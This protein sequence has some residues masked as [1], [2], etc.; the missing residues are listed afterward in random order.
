M[1]RP[2]IW[3][4]AAPSVVVRTLPRSASCIAIASASVAGQGAGSSSCIRPSCPNCFNYS[5]PT[6]SWSRSVQAPPSVRGARRSTCSKLHPA[7]RARAQSPIDHPT[8]VLKAPSTTADA[9]RPR[10]SSATNRISRMFSGWTGEAG[11]LGVRTR[12]HGTF[13][14]APATP[15]VPRLPPLTPNVPCPARRIGQGGI[16][17]HL[18][19]ALRV[20]GEFA[21]STARPIPLC[22]PER[23]MLPRGRR[24]LVW[25]PPT[26][27]VRS[28]VLC[29]NAPGK[30]P[31]RRPPPI[32]A[33]VLYREAPSAQFGPN[34][35]EPRL[36]PSIRNLAVNR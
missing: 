32:R 28:D 10:S 25:C 17:A 34:R 6:P 8:C 22:D 36:P 3:R 15:N 23:S 7:H 29:E 11:T 5:M 1:S 20:R 21:G 31:A 13:G 12:E 33:K 30:H 18:R 9:S 27:A 24:R 4:A 26:M 19:E 35:R 16:R 2:A 14:V